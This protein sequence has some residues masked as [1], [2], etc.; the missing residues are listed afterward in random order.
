[1]PIQPTTLNHRLTTPNKLLEAIAVGV[2]VVAS[3]LPGMAVIATESG[4][5]LCDPEDP[6]SI[7]AAVRRILGLRQSGSVKLD[8]PFRGTLAI[9]LEGEGFAGSGFLR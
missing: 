7:A 8:R 6:V 9:G 1:M 3:D 5:E 4:G 2:P